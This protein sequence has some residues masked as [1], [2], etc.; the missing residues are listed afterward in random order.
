MLQGFH[1]YSIGTLFSIIEFNAM[2][3]EEFML[4][5]NHIET[6]GELL[7]WHGDHKAGEQHGDTAVFE[8]PVTRALCFN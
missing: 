3:F 5:W 4:V 2:M 8:V 6:T 7:N 1:F